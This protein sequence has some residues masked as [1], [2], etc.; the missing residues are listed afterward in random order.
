MMAPFA[1]LRARRSGWERID[2]V[3]DQVDE[4]LQTA[5][6]EVINQRYRITLNSPRFRALSAKTR[7]ARAA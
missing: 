7:L 1:R 2:P 6:F 5:A 4:S 3:I